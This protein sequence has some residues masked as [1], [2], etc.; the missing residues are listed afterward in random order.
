MQTYGEGG[1]YQQEADEHREVGDEHL[2]THGCTDVNIKW[3][4][5]G[6]GEQLHISG[7]HFIISTLLH[8]IDNESDYFQAIL[9]LCPQNFV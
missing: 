1:L 8:Q 6:P 2:E 3:C 9:P 7:E 4:G 5:Q